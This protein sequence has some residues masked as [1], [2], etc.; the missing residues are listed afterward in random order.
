MYGLAEGSLQGAKE[1]RILPSDFI[2]YP[3][4]DAGRAVLEHFRFS[5]NRENAP[6]CFFAFRT[7]N[8]CALFLEML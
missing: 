8:R 5:S 3:Q 6:S 7:E 2:I 4:M 1:R